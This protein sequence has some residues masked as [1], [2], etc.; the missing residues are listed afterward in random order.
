MPTEISGATGVNKVQ[1]VAIEHLDLPS[2]SVLQVVRGTTSTNVAV[3][4]NTPV[5]IGL[6]ATITPKATSS[7]ILIMFGVAGLVTDSTA[8]RGFALAVFRGST[9]LQQA[10]S[11]YADGY[12]YMPA[13][14]TAQQYMS[15]SS[16]DYLDSPNTTSATT[17]NIYGS[18]Y[19]SRSVDLNA[20]NSISHITLMEIAG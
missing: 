1:T 6:S 17:Y 16:G 12:L 5:S 11:D 2:G 14:T 15:R 10:G 13:S 9:S 20:G 4:S 3:T 18:T 19:S 7:K 8:D